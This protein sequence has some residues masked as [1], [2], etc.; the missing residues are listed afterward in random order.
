VTVMSADASPFAV[1]AVGIYKRFAGVPALRGCDLRVRRGNIHA[2]LGQN[3]AGKSTLVKILNGVY[4]RDSFEGAIRINNRPVDFR[5]PAQ[6]HQCG[7][8]YVPQEIEVIEP[9]SVAENLFAGQ[10]TSRRSTAR[11]GIF[12]HRR[13]LESEARALLE[14]LGL[15]FDPSA[16][17]ASLSAAQRHLVMIAR[18]LAAHPAVLIL[19]EPT[20]SLSSVEIKRLFSILR[21]LQLRGTAMIYI[22]HRLPE[23]FALC[24]RASVIRDGLITDEFDRVQFNAD[25]FIA[26]ISG[27]RIDSQ[28]P[29]PRSLIQRS[30]LLKVEHLSV[31]HR[32]RQRV[33]D[34]CFELHRG[35][36][37]GIAG[38][39]GAGRSELLSALY[40]HL[41]HN[42]RVALDNHPLTIRSIREARRAGI[43]LLSEDRKRDGLLFN[44]PVRCNMMIG[45]LLPVARAGLVSAS[46]ERRTVFR[47]LAAL[48]VK[49]PSLDASVTHLSGGNQQKLL[50]ARVLLHA[51]RVLLLDEPSKGVDVATRQ[52]IYRLVVALA[53]QGIG[54]IV[55]SSEL[56]EVLGIAD[57]CLVMAEGRFIDE[58]NRGEGSEQRI[59]ESI[60]AHQPWSTCAT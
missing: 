55:V 12:V 31:T 18:A 45:N 24:D 44:V 32:G 4:P 41:P 51:P 46:R 54:V 52:D 14:E 42:G 20:A 13:Q 5:S 33:R 8:G 25:R 17:V 11:S 2:L 59:L 16:P 23:V 58:F 30:T 10:M 37:L 15:L 50:F 21:T 48:N 49:A 57:R 22:T 35:E 28:Y 38:L 27:R 40:G 47:Q 36:I 53:D 1:E 43:A 39:L 9:L 6:A 60:A 26:A 19:D 3:G 34:V 7:I 29:H 56:E